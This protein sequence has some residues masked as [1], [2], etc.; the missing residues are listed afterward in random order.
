[1]FDTLSEISE[2]TIRLICFAGIFGAVALWELAA[3]RRGL[4]FARPRR[5]FTNLAIV[6]IDSLAL[7]L[8]FPILAV[9]VAQYAQNEGWGLAAIVDLPAWL[10]IVIAL[11]L[12]DLAIYGQHVASHKVPLLWRVHKMH[13]ADRDF[14]VTTALRFHPV[15]I[16]L[17]MLWKFAVIIALG[18]DPL[19]VFLFEVLLNGT[20]MFN[21]GNIRLPLAADRLVR[22]IVVTPDM[23]RV[24]HSIVPGETDSN[25]GFNLSIWDR[26][27]KTYTP[28]P[29]AGHGAMTI[30]LPQYQSD[31]PTQLAWS[32]VLPFRRPQKD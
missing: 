28:Q 27:F 6:V 17:S 18:A 32:L 3:P 22:L 4:L 30:G 7:R 29:Q 21:H 1:M 11:I 25:Y 20:A 12:L 2:S 9:G 19:A 16:C 13:H 23:H 24:H 5:W 31:G 15:E 10:E 8:L 26:M 14:D